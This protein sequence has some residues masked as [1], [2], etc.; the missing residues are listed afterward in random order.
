MLNQDFWLKEGNLKKIIFK[1][2]SMIELL[3]NNTKEKISHNSFN[4]SIN[5]F[6]FTSVELKMQL[7]TIL[8][9]IQMCQQ[10]IIENFENNQNNIEIYNE[11]LI[12]YQMIQKELCNSL[13][14]W[15]FGLKIL[16]KNFN[17]TPKIIKN[18]I[19]LTNI[20]G[21]YIKF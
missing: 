8:T 14:I 2:L 6:I 7:E 13:D 20:E 11:L 1:N 15:E 21:I 18:E 9:R 16:Q 5:K 10:T 3:K 4:E 12:N 17:K 19:S